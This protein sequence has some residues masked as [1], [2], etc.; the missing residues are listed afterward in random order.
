VQP[1][2]A[3]IV[4]VEWPEKL[5]Y[6]IDKHG[7]NDDIIIKPTSAG[8]G[9]TLMNREGM[10]NE[11]WFLLDGRRVEQPQRGLYIRNGKKIIVR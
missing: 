3:E 1:T 8:I 4:S 7:S 6:N 10:D 9:A 5:C 11:V 2:G